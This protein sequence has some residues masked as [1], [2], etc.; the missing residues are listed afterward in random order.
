MMEETNTHTLSF[1]IYK[2]AQSTKLA[3]SHIS[4]S[5]P[6]ILSKPDSFHRKKF[7][8]FKFLLAHSSLIYKL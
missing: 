6:Y 4:E 1:S 5:L 7:N 8:T 3:D 2:L